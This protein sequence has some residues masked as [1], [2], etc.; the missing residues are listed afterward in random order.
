MIPIYNFSEDRSTQSP[1]STISTKYYYGLAD[2]GGYLNV[3]NEAL[4]ILSN[5]KTVVALR[6]SFGLKPTEIVIELK[7]AEDRADLMISFLRGDLAI[8]TE[9]GML[10]VSFSPQIKAKKIGFNISISY[11]FK[12]LYPELCLPKSNELD[13]EGDT[14]QI[15]FSRVV[16]DPV[17]GGD[18]TGEGDLSL[19]R[20]ELISYFENKGL[21]L[22]NSLEATVRKAVKSN[23]LRFKY[24]KDLANEYFGGETNEYLV[25]GNQKYKLSDLLPSEMGLSERND[26]YVANVEHKTKKLSSDRTVINV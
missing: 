25:N 4:E 7:A 23:A 12:N 6:P 15:N 14:L 13:V 16:A 17:S 9:V 26:I 20:R 11:E 22:K 2:T 3:Y 8:K 18:I 24:V 10:S 5:A 21:D 19:L 1:H